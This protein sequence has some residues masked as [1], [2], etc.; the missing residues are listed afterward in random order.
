MDYVKNIDLCRCLSLLLVVCT[1]SVEEFTAPVSGE[2]KLECWGASGHNRFAEEPALPGLGGYAAASYQIKTNHIIYICVGGYANGYN[3]KCDY[4]GGG[5]GG[6]ATSIT[7]EIGAEL[8]ELSNKQDNKDKVLLVAG[9]GGGIER[10]G[11]AG[12]GG[13]LEGL[14]GVSTWDVV[15]AYGTGGTQNAG[16]LN[17]QGNALYPIYLEYK[18]CFGAGGIAAQNTGTSTNPHMD[19]GAQGGGGWYGG[20]GTG[21]AGAA[22]GGSSYG[23]TSLLVKDSFVTIGGDHKMPSPYGGTETGHL[24]HGACV[25]SWF[26]KQ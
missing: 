15:Q 17:N 5:L 18:A 9:G 23:N 6:G 11:K 4:T 2:Y 14:D 8:K 10:P 20:G 26:L 13:R 22:G 7:I 21:L 1:Q 19:F 16:G 3:N 24:G 25:I 12:S